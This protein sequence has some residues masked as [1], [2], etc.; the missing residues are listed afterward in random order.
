L[1]SS[2]PLAI[3]EGNSTEGLLARIFGN[4]EGKRHTDKRKNNAI[5]V[6]RAIVE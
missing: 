3:A 6:M 4:H 5:F 1:P 2:T